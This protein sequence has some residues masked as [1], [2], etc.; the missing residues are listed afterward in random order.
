MTKPL[1]LDSGPLG[2]IAHPRPNAEIALWLEGLVRRD[3]VVYLP[4]IADY[5][6]RRNFL[7]P[8]RAGACRGRSGCHRKRRSPVENGGSAKLERHPVVGRSATPSRSAISSRLLVCSVSQRHESRPQNI[9]H[10]AGLQ[11]QTLQLLEDGRIAVALVIVG[12]SNRYCFLAP[13][14]RGCPLRQGAGPP[15]EQRRL[16][17]GQAAPVG[18]PRSAKM[19]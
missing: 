3:R 13:G 19:K 16:P 17:H 5:E 15:A 18:Q 11:H 4:E 14:A 2:R 6:V 12:N 10:A 1:A 9:G 8:G 7:L